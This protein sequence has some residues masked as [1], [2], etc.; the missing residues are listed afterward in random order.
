M[1]KRA[2]VYVIFIILS[3][4]VLTVVAYFLRDTSAP[5]WLS[6]A[7][8]TGLATISQLFKS[9][10]PSHQLYH[11]AIIFLFAGVILLDPFL[12]SLVVLIAHLVEWAKER[13]RKSNHLKA[14][15]LQPFNISMHIIVGITAQQIYLRINPIENDGGSFEGLVAAATAALVYVILNHL[16]VGQALV[17]ARKVSWS[18][19]GILHLEN[20]STD[21]VMTMIGFVVAILVRL[22]PL[23]ILP[24]LTPLY[25][26]YRALAVPILKQQAN[27]DPKTGLWNAEYF[28]NALDA[29]LSR[30][31][32]YNRP[33]TVVMADL[34]LLRNINN[35]YGHLG[36]DAV[37]MGVA[38]TLRDHLREYDVIA[39]FGGEEFAILMPEI[40]PEDAYLRVENVRRAVERAEFEAPTTRKRIKATM[41]FGI[42]GVNGEFITA[43]EIIHHADVAVYAAKMRGRNCTRFYSEEVARTLG[44][45]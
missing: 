44:V 17:L 42:T 8:L 3:G 13:L 40:F 14:W 18:E 29:E 19:S 33:L 11:P 16:L 22:N 4:G 34:D 6:F 39:R 15:Y 35:A 27:T 37:L 41:S 36:G 25:L 5:T 9:E 30:T 32:R 7:L 12:F 38:Q 23:W 21:F 24:P 28:L 45:V 10:A 31:T 1:S 2:W 20:L 43:K 26:I